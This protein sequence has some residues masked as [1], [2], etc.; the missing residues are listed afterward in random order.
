MN[1]KRI[2]GLIYKSDQDFEG[3]S[4][5][6][7]GF[8]I[9]NDLFMSK[10]T[11]GKNYFFYEF[12]LVKEDTN[13]RNKKRNAIILMDGNIL[14][15]EKLLRKFNYPYSEDKNLLER[16]YF[17][18]KNK[19]QNYL[20]GNFSISIFDIDEGR[21]EIIRDH[22]GT[23]PLFYIDT[24]KYFAFASE[25]KFLELIPNISLSPNKRKILQYLCQY[26]EN[27]EDTFYEEIFSV[28]PSTKL[29]FKNGRIKFERFN[30]LDEE[31]PKY[32]KYNF[33]EAKSKLRELLIDSIEER[34][35][36][37]NK[38][39]C[40]ISGGLDSSAIYASAQNSSIRNDLK[41]FSMN[42]YDSEGK[43]KICDESFYQN[44][45]VDKT[46]K[47]HKSIE[48]KC[49]S[50]YVNVDEWLK[51]YDQPFDLANAYLYQRLYESINKTSKIDILLDGVDG[52]SVVS[53]GW[54]RFKELFYLKTIFIFFKEI[55]LFSKK[56]NYHEYLPNKSILRRFLVPLLK[57]IRL[58]SPLFW[59]KSQLFPKQKPKNRIVKSQ[60]LKEI[61][62][63]ETYDFSRNYLSHKE[64]M[65]N[66]LAESSF[67][68]INILFF[69]YGI[70]QESPFFDIRVV[71]LCTSLPSSFKLKNGESR[72]ILRQSFR[73]L[74]PKEILNR[75]SK[76]N[77]T[78][79][80]IDS[81]SENDFTMIE[82]E[83]NT[84]HSLI[85]KEIDIQT[86]RSELEELKKGNKSER[87]SMSIW[88][89]YLVNRWLKQ[90][91]N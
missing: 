9:K 31:G 3:I 33:T 62:F 32:D 77:L 48:Y 24:D 51:R 82:K 20:R 74:I 21:L 44:K 8:S 84:V 75:Y 83:I 68:N 12:S 59:F 52:D 78:H 10:A 1:S 15:S 26:K 22:I 85:E 49:H 5:S 11:K 42:F 43:P 30:Y 50:P 28:S 14:N 64:K 55:L 69:N 29:I 76:S 66:P 61:D 58:L 56:H 41:T 67:T 63:K 36:K 47:E 71:N 23:K 27:S 57:E 7:R 79:N 37:S 88:C 19:W 16:L 45:L 6:V 38:V 80:F 25:I 60:F 81:I 87:S 54:E 86:L 13:K 91:G 70:S 73:N 39:A 4:E 46:K 34:A 2:F 40:L 89:F 72:Y 35:S 65:R 18:D 53:H 17:K 90:I